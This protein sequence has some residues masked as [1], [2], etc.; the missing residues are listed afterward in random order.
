MAL[1]KTFF[2]EQLAQRL[3]E[4]EAVADR[5][6]HDAREA[7]RSMAT[8]SEKK[9]DGRAAIEYGQMATAQAARSR[10]VQED[11]KALVA[12]SKRT[13]PPFDARTPIALGAIVDVAIDD[14]RGKKER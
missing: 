10:K 6:E 2:V 13:L 12:F 7:A 9:E 3:K 4:S 14:A 5:A 1:D 11:L 8:E